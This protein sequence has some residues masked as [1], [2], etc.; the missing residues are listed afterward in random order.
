MT[1]ASWLR[2]RPQRGSHDRRHALGQDAGE[3]RGAIRGLFKLDPLPRPAA[4]CRSSSRVMAARWPN[5]MQHWP[6]SG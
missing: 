6:Y 3:V 1:A 4:R 5:S 2:D